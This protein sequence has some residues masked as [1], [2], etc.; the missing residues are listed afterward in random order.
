MTSLL[1]GDG[2]ENLFEVRRRNPLAGGGHLALKAFDEG[3][4]EVDQAHDA[5]FRVLAHGEASHLRATAR[6]RGRRS[7]EIEEMQP[8]ML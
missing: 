2:L 8:E 5:V 7:Y 3:A 6:R 1:R 4:K